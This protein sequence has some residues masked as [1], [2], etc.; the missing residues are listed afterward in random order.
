MIKA[1]IKGVPRPPAYFLYIHSMEC[2]RRL[3]VLT[4]SYTEMYQLCLKDPCI[5]ECT[6]LGCMFSDTMKM[7]SQSV[8]VRADID[9]IP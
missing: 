8:L 5:K 7:L 4:E 3:P 1:L 2:H 6:S 9:G